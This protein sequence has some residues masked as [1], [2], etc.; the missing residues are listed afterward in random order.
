MDVVDVELGREVLGE[1]T[2]GVVE[3]AA[4]AGLVIVDPRRASISR[5]VAAHAT[6]IPS[7][8]TVDIGPGVTVCKRY[9]AGSA[10]A[11]FVRMNTFIRGLM[12]TLEQTW[13]H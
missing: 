1:T 9:P 3:G 8:Q 13:G 11:L 2:G 6:G 7:F 4:F 10:S 5:S 12:A